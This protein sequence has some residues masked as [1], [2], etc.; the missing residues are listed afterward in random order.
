[1]AG[2]GDD[3]LRGI[4]DKKDRGEKIYRDGD[5]SGGYLPEYGI[6]ETSVP[7]AKA[8][9]NRNPL[10]DTLFQRQLQGAKD[11]SNNLKSTSDNLYNNVAQG[12][13]AGLA[14]NIKGIRNNFNARGLLKSGGEA[15]AELGAQAKTTQGLQQAR[16]QINQGLL[17]NLQGMQGNAFGTAAGLAQPGPNIADPYLSGI[18]TDIASQMQ[19]AQAQGQAFGQISQGVGALGG[20][21][22]ANA[23]QSQGMQFG[24]PSQ[25]PSYYNSSGSMYA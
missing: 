19:D 11:Y 22:L 9:M 6:G 10:A 12:A 4:Q 23:M 5:P 17:S 14:Q 1:M 3:L 20:Y 21:G 2:L 8:P 24:K 15:G 25:L 16:G 7:G 18:G 13:R